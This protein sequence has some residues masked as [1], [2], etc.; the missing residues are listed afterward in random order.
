MEIWRNENKKHNYGPFLDEPAAFFVANRTN[1][2]S[3]VRG[4]D[5]EDCNGVVKCGDTEPVKEAAGRKRAERINESIWGKQIIYQWRGLFALNNSCLP[6]P[7]ARARLGSRKVPLGHTTRSAVPRYQYY[8]VLNST[9]STSTTGTG[10]R[11]L[12]QSGSTTSS[13]YR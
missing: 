10:T 3:K 2:K 7:W 12:V 9:S 8:V 1:G 5:M 6:L 11:G 13:T 4:G